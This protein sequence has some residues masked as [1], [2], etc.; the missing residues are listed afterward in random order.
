[1]TPHPF[2]HKA[3]SPQA[4]TC[5]SRYELDHKELQPTAAKGASTGSKLCLGVTGRHVSVCTGCNRSRQ[6]HQCETA[7]AAVLLLAQLAGSTSQAVA[8]LPHTLTLCTTTASAHAMSAR[9]LFT[10]FSAPLMQA[11]SNSKHAESFLFGEERVTGQHC[12]VI[13]FMSAACFCVDQARFAYTA[14]QEQP[15]AA[16]FCSNGTH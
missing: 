8:L 9:N 7:A 6:T 16:A 2:A 15:G 1:V 5:V 13:L 11:S 12:T 3:Q 14:H 4:V 10:A